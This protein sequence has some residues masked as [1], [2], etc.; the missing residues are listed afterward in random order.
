VTKRY[1]HL[2]PDAFTDEDRLRVRLPKSKNGQR[3]DSEEKTAKTAKSQ[4]MTS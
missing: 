4:Q 1:A 3:M 2:R